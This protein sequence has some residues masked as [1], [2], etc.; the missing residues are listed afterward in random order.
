[1]A[2]ERPATDN[3]AMRPA[4]ALHA[5]TGQA[6]GRVRVCPSVRAAAA[7]SAPH[8]WLGARRARPLGPLV[9]DR[10][11]RAPRNGV[12]NSAHGRRHQPAG[13]PQQVPGRA[14]RGRCT[15]VCVWMACLL[16]ILQTARSR[17]LTL[18][19]ISQCPRRGTWHALSGRDASSVQ[20]RP[21]RS[22]QP[23][24]PGQS[25]RARAKKNSLSR[26]PHSSPPQYR[27]PSSTVTPMM[28]PVGSAVDHR[29]E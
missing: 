10:H 17:Q 23:P 16:C 24:H 2:H 18:P 14:M 1:M 22:P 15:C 25:K 6:A 19:S 12:L 9:L 5:S 8:L 4:T 26:N 11:A 7:G 28:T 27:P 13:R 20:H 3:E 29:C 21:H